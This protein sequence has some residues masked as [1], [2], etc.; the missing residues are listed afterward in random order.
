MLVVQSNLANTY[1]CLGRHDDALR[2]RRDVYSGFC[3]W[4]GEEHET[5]ITAANNYAST[6][7][8]LNRHDEVKTLMRKTLPVARRAL[9]DSNDT[10]LRTRSLYAQALYSNPDATL[11]DLREA[12][13]TLEETART[14]R[15]VLGGA[16]PVAKDIEWD[17]R[18]ARE[19]LAARET[20]PPGSG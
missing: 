7:K 5:S 3:K 14:A 6:L 10:T 19:V 17:L 2:M 4:E 13:T 20:P 18:N 12:L 11:D 9:G 15:R 8:R 16:H 1:Q